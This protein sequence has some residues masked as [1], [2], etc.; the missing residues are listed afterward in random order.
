MV[1][2]GTCSNLEQPGVSWGGKSREGP[3]R[4]SACRCSSSAPAKDIPEAAE[5]V[6]AATALVDQLNST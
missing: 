1:L 2:F 6:T 3:L 4:A 5:T